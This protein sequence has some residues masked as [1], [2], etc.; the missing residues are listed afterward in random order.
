MSNRIVELRSAQG[1]ALLEGVA[2]LW[3]LILLAVM[4]VSLLVN[5]AMTVFYQQ[6][7]GF[8]TNQAAQYAAS[9]RVWNHVYNLPM[10]DVCAHTTDAVNAMLL[11]MGLPKACSVEVVEEN[12][13]LTT[14]VELKG[15]ALPS[16]QAC[17]P[18]VIAIKDS[19]T[20][21]ISHNQPPCFLVMRQNNHRDKM[22]AI[23]SFGVTPGGSIPHSRWGKHYKGFTFRLNSGLVFQEGIGPPTKMSPIEHYS[24]L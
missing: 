22:I 20:A 8:V 18:A 24:A 21:N 15:I 7:L 19:A 10:P 17:L 5:I 3:Y 2:G 11:E 14:T 4:A 13:L 9:L 23:P 1:V 6:K 16:R 12:G